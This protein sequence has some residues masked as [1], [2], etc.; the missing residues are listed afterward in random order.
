VVSVHGSIFHEAVDDRLV[1]CFENYG[2]VID[3]VENLTA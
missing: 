2:Q 3:I 1:V